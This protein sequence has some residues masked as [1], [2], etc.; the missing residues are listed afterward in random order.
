MSAEKLAIRTV[1]SDMSNL[2]RKPGARAL[3]IAWVYSNHS[4][5]RGGKILT[6]RA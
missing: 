2:G 3:S 5:L 4:H 6:R 1:P